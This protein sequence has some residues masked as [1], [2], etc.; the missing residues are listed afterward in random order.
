MGLLLQALP[1]LRVI[2]LVRD[3]RAVALSRMRAGDS[4]LG[5]YTRSSR[6]SAES[7]VVAEASLYCH[8]VTADIRSRLALERE[9]PDRILLIRYEDVIANPEQT[10]RD[11]YKFLDEPLPRV[12]LENMQKMAQ[13]GQ[14]MNLSTKWQGSMAYKEAVTIVRKCAEFFSLLN[15]SLIDI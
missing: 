9:F 12:T 6:K 4:F 15:I 8:H 5:A 7:N 1:S 14:S 10:F 11:I 13:K 2:H 3:P